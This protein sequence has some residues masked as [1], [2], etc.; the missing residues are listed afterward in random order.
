M[1]ALP[2][3]ASLKLVTERV[4]GRYYPERN[5]IKSYFALIG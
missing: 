3:A 4:A 5:S 2:E 1:P